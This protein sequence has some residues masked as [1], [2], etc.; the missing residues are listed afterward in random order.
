MNIIQ[1][2]LLLI[3]LFVIYRVWFRWRNH[4]INRREWLSWSLF[5]LL[6]GIAILLPKTTDLIAGKLGLASGRGV[7]MIVYISIP[8]LFYVLF[9]LLVK[10]DNLEQNI[11]KITRHLAL[12]E[13]Q[14]KK[15]E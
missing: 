6:A 5:W 3:V 4:D 13:K 14:E 7:D 9:R 12:S 2:L 8:L 1:Y 15:E 10:I 11:T